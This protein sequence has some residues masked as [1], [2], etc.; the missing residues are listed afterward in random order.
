MKKSIFTLIELL[1]VIAI[2][3]I[4]A[5]M[6]LPALNNARMR[7]KSLSCLSNLKQI[8]QAT[9]FYISD[10]DYIIASSNSSY[11][12]DTQWHRVLDELYLGN[13]H[14]IATSTTKY[15]DQKLFVCS[16]MQG[17]GMKGGYFTRGTSGYSSNQY[18]MPTSDTNIYKSNKVSQP[19]KCPLI[20]DA[21]DWFLNYWSFRF[22]TGYLQNLRMI[23]HGG[24]NFLFLDG[25][26]AYAKE[27]G[28][29]WSDR[30]LG[31]IFPSKSMNWWGKVYGYQFTGDGW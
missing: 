5:A 4:L 16:G 19:S 15:T 9:Q 26:A 6:L 11:L 18:I 14:N 1:V 10:Y 3:S 28:G 7:A 24:A 2:I 22:S 27:R 8:G 17:A 25:H 13:K 12:T 21:A 20:F 31:E 23:S 29:K 30:W